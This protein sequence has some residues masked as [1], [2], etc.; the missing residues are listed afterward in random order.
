MMTATDCPAADELRA[1]VQ[2]RLGLD[3]SEAMFAHVGECQSCQSELDT[4]SD[5][6]D[7]LIAALRH[8]GELEG[9]QEESNFPVAMAKALG[10]LAKAK[11]SEGEALL[12]N[13]PRSIGEYEIMR[14]L[15]QGG[16]GCVYLAKHT[17]L[18]REVALKVL[19]HNRLG[20]PRVAARFETEMQAVGRLSHP[21]IVTA[22]DARDV[23]GTA[24]L[25]TE[26]IDGYDLGEVLKRTGAISVCDACEL[27]RQAAVAL[28]YISEQG[29]IH[30][31]VK[32][33][34]IMLARDGQTKL[35]DLGLARLQLDEAAT[36]DM[37]H[38]G[39]A[40][41]TADYMAPEQVADSRSV[42]V[43]A[44]IYS[45]GCTLFKLLTGKAP[46]ATQNHATA[47]AKMTAHVSSPP[48]NLAE[49]CANAP[50]NLVKLV[51]SM[52]AKEPASRPRSAREVV[53][54]LA[55]FTSGHDLPALVADADQS[56]PKPE[57]LVQRTALPQP[58][59]FFDR[60]YPF[61]WLIATALGGA[62]FGFALG[63][64][65]KITYPDGTTVSQRVPEGSSVEIQPEGQQS[66][67]QKAETANSMGASGAKGA[68]HRPTFVQPD[69]GSVQ[70]LLEQAAKLYEEANLMGARKKYDAAWARWASR[71]DNQL[72]VPSN[73]LQEQTK[74]YRTL[75]S[76]LDEQFPPSGFPFKLLKNHSQEFG[77]SSA[78]VESLIK[79]LEHQAQNAMESLRSLNDTTGSGDQASSPELVLVKIPV[80]YADGRPA[81][82]AEVTLSMDGSEERPV[83][84]TSRAEAD[85]LAFNRKLPYGKY[86]MEIRVP[87]GD[88][89]FLVGGAQ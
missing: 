11:T 75:L 16:M 3:E 56:E 5:K 81:V 54:Q 40:M 78:E 42:D 46:F 62:A 34:N 7:S 66:L 9:F 70:E 58:A 39:Q 86:T 77:V 79:Q 47:Y 68:G 61:A 24:V 72:P 27:A 73:I 28:A 8:P 55:E 6:E 29:F 33:S 44:D 84:A 57:K 26:F 19:A 35:L 65:V 53:E 22:H 2:G 83:R 48:P 36:T 41:G 12:H 43:R 32:P 50:S 25:V 18:G 30:R 87:D 88:S 69:E 63:L 89:E 1:L 45:L 76:Q 20:D 85:G 59:S 37:T 21:N 10:A 60:R 23:D 17:K 38:T 67:V 14:P 15:G 4:V 51:H 64:I 31:D 13:V 49:H 82:G 74:T 52:L 71:A 80:E